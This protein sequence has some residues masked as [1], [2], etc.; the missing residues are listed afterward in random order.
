MTVAVV[1]IMMLTKTQPLILP[2]LQLE[3]NGLKGV[4]NRF[5]GLCLS[6]HSLSIHN[7][8]TVKTVAEVRP[9]PTPS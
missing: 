2:K 5:N 1:L 7:L 8:K 9:P 6:S 3:V 4:V